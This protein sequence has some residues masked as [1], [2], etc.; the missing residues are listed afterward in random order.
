MRRSLLALLFV[1]AALSLAIL[2]TVAPVDAQETGV[3]PDD[4][5]EVEPCCQERVAPEEA[6]APRSPSWSESP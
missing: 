3:D 1:G 5:F 2:P 6:E 4:E